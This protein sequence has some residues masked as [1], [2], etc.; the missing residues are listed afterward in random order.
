MTGNC[1]IA[2]DVHF[3]GYSLLS[4]TPECVKEQLLMNTCF[5]A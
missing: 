5:E 2:I 3:K 4:L 1:C